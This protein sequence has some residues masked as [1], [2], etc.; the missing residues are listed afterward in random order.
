MTFFAL[1][2]GTLC[3]ALGPWLR[4]IIL[5]VWALDL[6]LDLVLDYDYDY[7]LD[8]DLDYDYDYVV[9]LD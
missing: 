6:Y 5:V 9:D 7:D 4:L 3:L 1:V 2:F 8:Y